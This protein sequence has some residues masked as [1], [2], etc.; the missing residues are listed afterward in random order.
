MT[1]VHSAEGRFSAGLPAIQLDSFCDNSSIVI[2]PSG[3]DFPAGDIV[4]NYFNS[5]YYYPGGQPPLARPNPDGSGS[6]LAS[7]QQP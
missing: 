5:Y 1:A 4:Y 6:R 7:A 3:P 2:G